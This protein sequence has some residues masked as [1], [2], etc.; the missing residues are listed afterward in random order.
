[1]LRA[2]IFDIDDTLQDWQAAIDRALREVLEDVA[3][4]LR[5]AVPE[6]L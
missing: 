4:E 6:R 2:V 5:A 3:P 1:M